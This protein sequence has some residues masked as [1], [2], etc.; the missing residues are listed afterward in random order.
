[1]KTRLTTPAL[2]V[3]T[4][5][6]TGSPVGSRSLLE[7]AAMRPFSPPAAPRALPFAAASERVFLSAADRERAVKVA[8]GLV[9]KKEVLVAGRRF[10]ND[11]TGLISALYEPLGLRL[12]Q[13]GKPGENGVSSMYRYLQRHGTLYTDARP[14][15]GDLVFFDETYDVN[16]DGRRNDGL[17]HVGLVEATDASGTVTVIHRTGQGVVRYQMNLNQRNTH[18]GANGRVLNDYLR[19]PSGGSKPALTSQLFMSF[20]TLDEAPSSFAQR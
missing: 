10:P 8:Q 4:A 3:L 5:C 11:C 15:P 2:F 7:T 14:R 1:M 18:R 12:M 13:G 6:A 16:R 9:G 17:T 19:S 20:G